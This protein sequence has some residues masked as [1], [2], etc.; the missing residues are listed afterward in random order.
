M[1]NAHRALN[2]CHKGRTIDQN[3][4]PGNSKTM[5]ARKGRGGGASNSL[6]RSDLREPRA[7]LATRLG[8]A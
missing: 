1:G 3:H 7:G 4:T 8:P 6:A 2:A 5:G